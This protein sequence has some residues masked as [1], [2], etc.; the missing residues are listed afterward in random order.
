MLNADLLLAPHARNPELRALAFLQ[1]QF[2]DGAKDALDSLIPF[3]RAAID[4]SD[5]KEFS[6]PLV[7][8]YVSAK[9]GLDIP[10]YMLEEMRPRLV[11]DDAIKQDPLTRIYLN[12]GRPEVTQ[13]AAIDDQLTESID[14][15]TIQLAKYAAARGL[16]TPYA[17]T[18]WYEA[19]LN[20]FQVKLSQAVR[21]KRIPAGAI[22]SNPGTL[23]EHLIGQFIL[24]CEKG[25]PQSYDTIQK[26]YYGSLVAEF[27]LNLG[28]I[29]N[30]GE[31]QGLIVVYDTTVLMRLLG[32]SG[33]LLRRATLEL[34]QALQDL[35]CLTYYFEHTLN[36]LYGNIQTILANKSQNLPIYKETEAAL[37]K[38]EIT[39]DRIATLKATVEIELGKMN[40]SQH[41]ERYDNRRRDQYQI[42]EVEFEEDLKK[43]GLTSFVSGTAGVIDSKSLAIVVRL[44][45][46]AAERDIARSKAIFVTHNSLLAR[47]ARGYLLRTRLLPER[48]VSP[49][50]TV[51][52]MTTVGWLA[53]GI[54]YDPTRI[55]TELIANCYK[56]ALPNVGWEN[57]FWKKMK[58]IGISGDAA[59]TTDVFRAYTIREIALSESLGN[60]H[61]FRT[62]NMSEVVERAN[63]AAR[64]M[65]EGARDRGMAEGLKNAEARSL[66]R[67]ETI[68]ADVAR[69][70]TEGIKW[71][72]VLVG[73]A[74]LALSF[75]LEN[76]SSWMWVSRIVAFAIA[77]LSF[78][79]VCHLTDFKAFD[80]LETKLF[81]GIRKAQD[82]IS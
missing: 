68:A 42:D 64:T 19:L 77:A 78:V 75:L 26:L 49:F 12:C 6:P 1:I 8:E 37:F 16:E 67:R 30:K 23:D 27:L 62:V 45:D 3:I 50:V 31:F 21:P 58:D 73:L 20:F 7:A 66:S 36:E 5:G 2:T 15:L 76:R 38:R 82:R 79:D 29:G 33:I 56:A 46:G 74:W 80:W 4:Q 71:L 70:L 10:L 25:D 43:T 44:R 65:E 69:N 13:Q 11:R 17:S 24:Q 9:F 28:S 51:G 22:I 47:R 40:I 53:N 39:L 63:T 41:P 81:Q 32:T 18:S 35:G 14:Q 60:I 72:V 57:E 34:H 61:L 52:Q 55:S 54:R 48:C 59:L